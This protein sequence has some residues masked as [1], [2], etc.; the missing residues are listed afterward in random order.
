MQEFET[1]ASSIDSAPD[2]ELLEA[3]L[4][5]ATSALNGQRDYY[6]YLARTVVEGSGTGDSIMRRLYGLHCRLALQPGTPA[7]RSEY[8]RVWVPFITMFVSLGPA[9]FG[10]FIRRLLGQSFSHPRNVRAFKDAARWMLT[11]PP[12]QM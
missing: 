12:T 1:I 6:D 9:F 2:S 7:P 4:S 8:D 11:R 5:S 10:R 3:L